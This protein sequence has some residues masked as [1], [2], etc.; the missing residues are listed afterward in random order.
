VALHLAATGSSSLG[1]P[2]ER[3][4]SLRERPSPEGARA[5]AGSSSARLW[6]AG[7][8]PGSGSPPLP[9]PPPPSS[10]QR[11]FPPPPLQL[12]PP[13]PP[14]QQ[15]QQA[16][17]AAAQSGLRAWALL[18]STRA[19]GAGRASSTAEEGVP[20]AVAVRGGG[21]ECSGEAG[22]LPA[23]ASFSGGGGS[24]GRAHEGAPTRGAGGKPGGLCSAAL[25]PRLRAALQRRVLLLLAAALVCLAAAIAGWVRR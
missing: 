24:G 21:E 5:G 3:L 22:A 12:P 17:P 7:G 9:P 19:A 6:R 20:F 8:A 10:P 11:Q 18:V 13:P 4:F 16:P 23:P 2:G 15:Q 25:L 14:Q 1:A